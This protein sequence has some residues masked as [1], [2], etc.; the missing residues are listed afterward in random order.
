MSIF[1]GYFLPLILMLLFAGVL[2]MTD[3]K[4]YFWHI[5]TIIFA[6]IPIGNWLILGTYIIMFL[7]CILEDEIDFKSNKVTKFLFNK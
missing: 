4:V 7:I 2:F 6:F 1:L 3:C 5:T